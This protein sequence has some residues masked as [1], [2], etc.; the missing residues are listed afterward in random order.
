MGNMEPKVA[1]LSFSNSRTVPHIV[2]IEPWGEDYTLM[3][4]EELQIVATIDYQNWPPRPD[5]AAA[6]FD[7]VE[8]DGSTQVYCEKTNDVKVMQGD[9]ELEIGHQRQSN[10]QY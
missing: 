10:L 7:I 2:W 8:N 5:D 9:R 4:G 3:P 1:K 6:F